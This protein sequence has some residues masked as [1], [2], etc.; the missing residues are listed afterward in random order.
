MRIFAGS[1]LTR[2]ITRVHSDLDEVKHAVRQPSSDRHR[3]FAQM[4]KLGL[5]K[6]NAQRV[7]AG[8]GSLMT[9]RRTMNQKS[10]TVICKFCKGTYSKLSFRKHNCRPTDNKEKSEDDSF[11]QRFLMMRRE[12]PCFTNNVLSSIMHKKIGKACIRDKDILTVGRWIWN[13]KEGKNQGNTKVIRSEVMRV[14]EHLVVLKVQF[15]EEMLKCGKEIDGFKTVDMFCVG[16]FD[17]LKRSVLSVAAKTERNGEDGTKQKL[18]V[19]IKKAAAILVASLLIQENV[20]KAKNIEQFLI[21]LEERKND[22]VSDTGVQTDV[23]QQAENGELEEQLM[24]KYL[25][26]TRAKSFKKREQPTKEKDCISDRLRCYVKLPRTR[27]IVDGCT[28]NKG[29]S[30]KFFSV[31]IALTTFKVKPCDDSLWSTV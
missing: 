12:D 23:S 21:I 20:G 16:N 29:M 18:F 2:H 31:L 13:T 22:I 27:G 5:Y 30:C 11:F 6:Q 26:K 7:M 15:E 1:Q 19:L 17:V 25:A 14:M 24:E 8:S 28:E 9:L 4:K 10:L 3:Y